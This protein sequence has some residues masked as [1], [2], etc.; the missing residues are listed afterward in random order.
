MKT[1]QKLITLPTIT[2]EI[3]RNILTTYIN[4]EDQDK[5]YMETEGDIEELKEFLKDEATDSLASLIDHM[6]YSSNPKISMEMKF[7]ETNFYN[8]WKGN[9]PALMETLLIWYNG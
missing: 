9:Y 2:F 4:S 6:N 3:P 1:F 5:G 8:H 7:Q